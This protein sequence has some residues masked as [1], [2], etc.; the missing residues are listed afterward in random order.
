MNSPFIAVLI[1][2]IIF[3]STALGLNKENAKYLL[4]GYNAMS[5]KERENFD[6][7]NYLTLLKKFFLILAGSSTIVFTLLINLL[8]AKIAVISYSSYL[9]IM[10]IW[11]IFK[12]NKFKIKQ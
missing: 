1:A 4:S 11:F 10:L 7:V 8:N 5:K 12:G 2:D 3:I 9:I 6:I